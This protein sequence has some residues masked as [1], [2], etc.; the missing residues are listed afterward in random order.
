MSALDQLTLPAER[1]KEMEHKCISGINALFFKTKN[2]D[3]ELNQSL[4]FC[5][6]RKR[7]D[8]ANKKENKQAINT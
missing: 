8:R 2:K 5:A 4:A 6:Q 1:V 3:L 7:R